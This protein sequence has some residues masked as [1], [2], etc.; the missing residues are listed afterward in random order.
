[1]RRTE[2]YAIDNVVIV[3]DLVTG[4]VSAFAYDNY[5]TADLHIAVLEA[6]EEVT[7]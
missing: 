3:R 7:Q 5:Q 6:E 1:M 4:N 2:Q